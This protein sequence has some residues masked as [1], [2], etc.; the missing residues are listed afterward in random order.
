ME[1]NLDEAVAMLWGRRL[2]VK[3][4]GGDDLLSCKWRIGFGLEF[5]TGL[6][7]DVAFDLD[8]YLWD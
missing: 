2:L 7:K 1:V 3:S 4:V 5:I 6:A 8:G